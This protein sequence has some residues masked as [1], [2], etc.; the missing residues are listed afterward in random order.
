LAWLGLAWPGLAWLGLAWLGLAWPGLA[1]F[2]LAWLVFKGL[3]ITS[4]YYTYYSAF[5]FVLIS[6]ELEMCY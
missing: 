2:G 3:N 4:P 6:C 5:S 1:W